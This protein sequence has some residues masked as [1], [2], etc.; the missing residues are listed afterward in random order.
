MSLAE[1]TKNKERRPTIP[2]LPALDG[3]R[4]L[5]VLGVLLFHD[6]KLEG[7]YLGVDL[8]FVLSG[9]LITSLLL[10]E[11]AGSGTIDLKTFWIRRARRLFPALLALLP[12]VALFSYFFMPPAEHARVRGDGIATLLYVANWHSVYSGRSYW[13]MFRS[14]SPLEHTWSLAIEEQFYIFWPL[15]AYFVLRLFKGSRFAMLGLSLGLALL[16]SFAMVWIGSL[17]SGTARAYMGTDTRGASILLGAALASAIALW[18][19]TQQTRKIR[20]LDAFGF[21]ST[22]LL[23]FAWVRLEGQDPRLYRGGFFLTELF[24]LVLIA[25][26]AHGDKS[27]VSRLFSIKPLA[28]VGQWSYGL[29]LYHWPA[30]VLLSADRTGLSGPL[31]TALRF[32]ATFAIALVSYRFLEQPIRKR[33]LYFGRPL[34]VLPLSV[35]ACLGVL[36]W[37]T[38]STPLAKKAILD[39]PWPRIIP[40]GTLRVLVLGDSVAQALGER[41]KLMASEKQMIVAERG[42]PDCSILEGKLPTRSLTNE[43]H[44]GG[45]CA[46]NW[47]KDIAEIHPDVTFV[48]LGGGHLAPVLVDGKWQKACEP[49][50]MREYGAEVLA[51]LKRIAGKSGKLVVAKA[52]YPIGVWFK[53]GRNEMID[54]LN[55][56]VVD[57]A[58]QVPGASILDLNA[59]LCPSGVCEKENAGEAIRPDGMHFGGP[60]A[61]AIASWVLGELK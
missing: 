49:G 42:T 24:V 29:Y 51:D 45:N 27:L 57:A 19:T 12:L 56:V 41:M 22:I 25:C 10:S 14:P 23:G 61:K 55:L 8:F 46:A 38:Q 39:L 18:G 36:V 40:E 13:D 35:A 30:F 4:G 37:G 43:P 5:A 53:E 2:H 33:G 58:K 3:L 47:E 21:I 7:G 16:S 54:C 15:L 44:K 20:L 11:W 28:Y 48:I 31:L 52:P 60:G 34:V 17:P 59:R 1:P 6:G 26:A 32:F 50:W 9:Y